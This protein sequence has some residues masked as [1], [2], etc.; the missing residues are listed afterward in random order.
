MKY[1]KLKEY[2]TLF[3]QDKISKIELICAISLWQENG[4]NIDD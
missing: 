4:A 2:F 1:S 3:Q